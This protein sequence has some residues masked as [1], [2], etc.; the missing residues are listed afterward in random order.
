MPFPV[1]PTVRG[2]LPQSGW[3]GFGIIGLLFACQFVYSADW[4]AGAIPGTVEF[5]LGKDRIEGRILTWTSGE[6]LLL[7]RDGRLRILQRALTADFRKTSEQFVPL[8]REELRGAL[9]HEFRGDFAVDSTPHYLV[10]RPS[11]ADNGLAEAFENF[12]REAWRYCHCRKLPIHE[13]LMPLV[14]VVYKDRSAY[15]KA[16]EV[17]AA[18]GRS[19]TLGLYDRFSNRCIMYLHRETPTSRGVS[20]PLLSATTSEVIRH[21]AFHQFAANTGLQ[22]RLTET[23]SWLAEGLAMAFE[24]SLDP[25]VASIHHSKSQGD[26]RSLARQQFSRVRPGWLKELISSDTR[27]RTD[28]PVAYILSWATVIYLNDRHLP[29][30]T[31]YLRHLQSR[32]PFQE[33]PADARL[34]DFEHFFGTSWETLEREIARFADPA[35]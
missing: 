2:S 20:S 29:Q 5:R 23:P 30:F 3:L 16:P 11:S 14:A 26:F 1:L 17:R 27:F 15:E 18:R 9:R 22:S 34:N 25:Q 31:A 12:F 8:S 24:A 35:K 19:P 33:Y 4:P 10:V 7:E 13:P 21:E 32:P 6:I 28:P